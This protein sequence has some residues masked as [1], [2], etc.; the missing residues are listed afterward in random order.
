M[1]F[2]LT[3]EEVLNA[4]VDAYIV[5]RI[6]RVVVQL[7]QCRTEEERVDYHVVLCAIAPT[8]ESERSQAGM[9]R[10]VSQRIGVAR[11]ARYVKGEGRKYVFEQ[12]IDRRTAYDE[13][14]AVAQH[15]LKPGDEATSRGQKCTVTQ[16]NYEADTCTLS[17]EQ[18]GVSATRTY[19]CIYKGVDP[20]PKAPFPRGSARLCRV[21]PSLRPSARETR[22]DEKAEKARSKVEELFLSEGASSP[23]QRDCVR[24]RLDVGVYE[25]AQ[26]L[27]VYAKYSA[28]YTLFCS[29]YPA[30]A[31]SF[32]A[33][34]KLRPWYVRRA[35]EESCLCKHCDNFKQQQSAFQ[36]L[37]DLLQPMCE[38]SSTAE[39]DDAP[40][41]DLEEA[42]AATWSG[43]VALEKLLIFGCLVS[44][45][46]MVKYMLCDG[47]LDGAGQKACIDGDC[48]HC[49]FKKLWSQGLRRHVVDAHQN[50]R[51]TAPIQFQSV[52]KWVRIRSS[53]QATPS[54]GKNTSY[55]AKQG[56]IV[57]FLDEFE[58]ESALKYPHHR[59]TIS[60]QKDADAAFQRQR[61][62]GWLGFDVDFAMDG[63]IP[64]PQGRSMQSDHWSPMS[65]TLF[66]NIVSWLR[67]DKWINRESCLE[68]GSR[69]TVEPAD[70][71]Q[72]GATEPARHS[73]WAE[74]VSVPSPD[75]ETVGVDPGLRVY[76]VRRHSATA[77][78]PPE[79]FERRLLRHRVLH[80]E[81][82]IHISDDKMHDS[83]AA[84]LFIN[85][86]LE[87]LDRE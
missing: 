12:A 4:R 73:F 38:R 26:A 44:K 20:E 68:K 59:F 74:V 83:H 15:D 5:N 39:A 22:H 56:T 80:T 52:V 75:A 57:Q 45:S 1:G 67:T 65:Y 55:E 76:G 62:P 69:V 58:R 23:A 3:E 21:P 16:I 24:R 33:F 14:A 9:I 50:L 51:P 53:K 32:S 86:T 29:R 27:F 34:K 35:K 87:S 77:D 70:T 6:K 61:T 7:K 49:G 63:T 13:A 41:D 8:R 19:S 78:T 11:G 71:S 10:A 46:K 31:I 54:E 43:R 85:K 42:E 60:R 25:T 66:V 82:F 17:F 18:G 81:A 48:P 40:E 72:P 47:A 30:H 36:A 84:Q 79:M 28:L 37:Y 64:P 2:G